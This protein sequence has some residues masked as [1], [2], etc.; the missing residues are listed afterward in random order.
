MSI[1]E[2]YVTESQVKAT[3][4]VMIALTSVFFVGRFGLRFW[5]SVGFQLEDLFV[6]LSWL[7]FL[8]MTIL[9]LIVLPRLYRLT[10]FLADGKIYDEFMDDALFIKK[11]FFTTTLLLWVSLWSVKFSLLVLYRRLLSRLKTEIRLWWAVLIF[12]VLNLIGCIISNLTSCSSLSAWFSLTG[13]TSDSEVKA[14]LASLYYSF[15]VDVITDIMIM[16]LPV[17]LLWSLQLPLVQKASL[18]GLFSIGF[19]CIAMATTRVIQIGSK[20]N[21]NSTPSSSW[22]AFWGILETGIAVIIGCLP[23]VAI[24]YRK[25]RATRRTYGRGYSSMEGQQ[26]KN[27]IPLSN[28]SSGANKPLVKSDGYDSAPAPTISKTK[29]IS[30]LQSVHLREEFVPS[31]P[32]RY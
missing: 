9:Y 29:G 30:V 23:A 26:N 18:G 20:A 5:K 1:S 11:I 3:G 10:A 17:K 24:I 2:N 14:Q 19:V 16:A 12:T 27:S 6:V 21:N 13:C 7:S 25:E 15:A 4:Y 32:P 8:A 31:R 28:A 22:L